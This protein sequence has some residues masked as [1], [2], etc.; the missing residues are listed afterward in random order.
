MTLPPEA[1]LARCWIGGGVV[2]LHQNR[3]S[4]ASV[5]QLTQTQFFMTPNHWVTVE[6]LDRFVGP[7]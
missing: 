6:S 1:R 3:V 7:W 4:L 5:D 2:A